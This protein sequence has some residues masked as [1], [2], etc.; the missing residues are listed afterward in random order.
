MTDNLETKI[1]VLE[2]KCIIND[3][4]HDKLNG[5]LERI[6][7]VLDEIKDRYANRT[8]PW[9]AAIIGVLGTIIGASL[10]TVGFLLRHG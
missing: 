5:S 8:P 9:V 7:G 3:N 2:E 4:M 1:A 6:W 10:A